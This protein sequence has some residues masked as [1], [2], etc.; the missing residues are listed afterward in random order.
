MPS[1]LLVS[2]IFVAA[3]WWR[4]K[5][6]CDIPPSVTL[7]TPFIQNVCW[8]EGFYVYKEIGFNNLHG[9]YGIPT[10][11]NNDGKFIG[12]NKLCTRNMNGTVDKLCEPMHKSLFYQYQYM[13]FVFIAMYL[14][15]GVPF[16]MIKLWNWEKIRLDRDSDNNNI[17]EEELIVR[18]FSEDVNYWLFRENTYQE[19]RCIIRLLRYFYP[20]EKYN[21]AWMNQTYFYLCLVFE[22]MV[23][24]LVVSVNVGTFV[25]TDY[26]LNGNFMKHGYTWQSW[27]NEVLPTYGI[28]E[29]RQYIFRHSNVKNDKLLFYLLKVKFSS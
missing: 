25:L 29:V 7:N 22:V 6:T 5:I 3:N 26:F 17:S 24:S 10:H 4:D 21:G 27:G 14:V 23:R 1:A 28:C 16:M 19:H 2:A 11:I 20:K 12:T 18:Y 9:L 13:H 15:Y 8:I